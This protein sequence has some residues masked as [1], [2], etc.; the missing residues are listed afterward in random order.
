[1]RKSILVVGA[2]ALLGG[3]ALPVPIQVA[4]WAID[5]FSMVTTEKSL[6]DHGISALTHKDCALHRAI[7]DDENTICRDAD[8]SGV[9][10]AAAGTDQSGDD[11]APSAKAAAL[12]RAP[13]RPGAIRFTAIEAQV[14]ESPVEPAK[15]PAEPEIAEFQTAGGTEASPN[16]SVELPVMVS[17]DMAALQPSTERADRPFVKFARLGEIPLEA[18]AT[19]VAA[20]LPEGVKP[21]A[22]A[23][24]LSGFYYVIGSFRAGDRAK[25]HMQTHYRLSPAVLH[26]KIGREARDVFRVVIGPLKSEER[27]GIFHRIKRA[28]IADT[29]A[30]RVTPEDWSVA[31]K[32]APLEQADAGA[33][34]RARDW[35]GLASLTMTR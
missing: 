4:S 16:S 10:V 27:A 26:G 30:I 12:S 31:A 18:S 13:G 5:V 6:T 32:S 11:I 17:V 34:L 2:C 28:G 33:V 29:W 23:K 9:L 24:P 14:A 1:M 21:T 8:D 3:C 22:S 15:L 35:P 20:V 19:Q 7:T 25:R